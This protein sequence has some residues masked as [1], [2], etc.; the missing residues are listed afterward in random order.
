MFGCIYYPCLLFYN[1]IHFRRFSASNIFQNSVFFFE[2]IL[3]QLS[4]YL[5]EKYFPVCSIRK[6][7]SNLQFSFFITKPKLVSFLDCFKRYRKFERKN[8]VLALNFNRNIF[9]VENELTLLG[10][11]LIMVDNLDGRFH[12]FGSMNKVI[13]LEPAK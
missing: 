13:T 7:Q 12:D 6:P 11:H 5:S 3:E 8:K 9:L 2:S 4:P 10:Y 1:L